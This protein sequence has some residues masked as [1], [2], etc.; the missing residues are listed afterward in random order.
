L[1]AGAFE[2][3]ETKGVAILRVNKARFGAAGWT[4]G[5]KIG[6]HFPCFAAVKFAVSNAIGQR[7]EGFDLT[8]VATGPAACPLPKHDRL[9]LVSGYH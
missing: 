6:S 4:D 1:G 9:F 8:G 3:S 5:L 7:N 2:V